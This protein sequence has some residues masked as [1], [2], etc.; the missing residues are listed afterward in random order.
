[1]KDLF[2]SY[3]RRDK[4]KVMK[5]V[6][7]LQVK[8]FTVW[9]DESGIE[10]G[11]QFKKVI[12]NAI[13]ECKVL[14][15]FSS[16]YSNSSP[17]TA[18]EIGVANAKGKPILP[19]KLD[20]TEYNEVVLFDLVNLDYCDLTKSIHSK[21]QIESLLT[22]LCKLVEITPSTHIAY[23]NRKR[24][25]Y[26][27]VIFIII[28]GLISTVCLYLS[29]SRIADVTIYPQRGSILDEY[30]RKLAYSEELYD[31]YIDKDALCG[32]DDRLIKELSDQ[33]VKTIK[34]GKNAYQY[35]SQLKDSKERYLLI[36]KDASDSLTNAIA[37]LPFFI[38]K[39]HHTPLIFQACGKRVY[40]YGNCFSNIVGNF[41]EDS[42][43][44]SGIEYNLNSILSGKAGTT[45]VT[46]KTNLGFDRTKT[47]ESG[48]N[49]RTTIN[50]EF[51][52]MVDS[53]LQVQVNKNEIIE[54]AFVMILESGTGAIRAMVSCDESSLHSTSDDFGCLFSSETGATFQTVTLS[55]LLED[56]KIGLSD[57]LPTNHGLI[58]EYPQ[59][60][61][62]LYVQN[63]ERK[64]GVSSISVLEGF[65]QSTNY[66]FRKLILNHYGN[67]P[68]DFF[69]ILHDFQID[70]RIELGVEPEGRYASVYLPNPDA[71]SWSN[72]AL[73]S[74]A[75]GYGLEIPQI[76]ILTFYNTIANG[77][78]RVKPYLVETYEKG[79][80]VIKHNKP[81]SLNKSIISKETVDSLKYALSLVNKEGTGYK[82]SNAF[83]AG[84]TGTTRLQVNEIERG[85][86]RDPYTDESGRHKYMASYIGFFPIDSPKY[87]VFASFKTQLTDVP[88]YGGGIPAE[89]T[90]NIAEEIC[91]WNPSL[92]ES[93]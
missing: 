25:T 65:I 23:E 18:K 33:M 67:S 91:R 55:V 10:T 53:L 87:T 78:K 11:E 50:L 79:D 29:I 12:V 70:E 62:D 59:I 43:C 17:W 57:I 89:I 7:L 69:D 64:H 2:I 49:V 88:L 81:S 6:T 80:K 13:E 84:K 34:D 28:L 52:Q 1:M 30:G 72:V 58:M 90:G 42:G 31:I 92:K 63:F 32:I 93:L 54:S 61:P 47:P 16:K 19:I 35:H 5:I 77:G 4:R 60:P 39:E 68:K 46:R 15:F 44:L 51:Q 75:I 24:K 41:L 85:S 40:P 83:I 9:M 37:H 74:L 73:T 71:E 8:G 82:L 76:N 86:S 14:V 45:Y 20:E 22:S 38:D 26:K 66:V 56:K 48:M 3:S 27:R 36:A 21:E